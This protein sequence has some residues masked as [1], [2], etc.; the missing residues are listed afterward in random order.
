MLVI[1]DIILDEY[2]Y[3]DP[4]GMSQE[5]PTIV[6]TP[7]DKKF[8]LGGAGIVAAHLVGLGAK[9]SIMSVTGNDQIASKVKDAL[10]EYNVNWHLVKDDNRPTIL[11]QRFRAGNK[12]LLR[13]SHLRSHDIPGELISEML[14]NFVR[15]ID[16]I[17]VV[18]FSDF[19][20]GC[21]PNLL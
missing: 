21:L 5:D 11:K 14:H 1:G 3:C 8:F 15:I 12:T 6:V 2:V 16:N 19:N 18:I 17:D 13:V 7:V 9:A 20:Y 10:D 4:L